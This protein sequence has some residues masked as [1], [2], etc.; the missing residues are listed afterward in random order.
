MN[1]LFPILCGTL[2]GLCCAGIR[3]ARRRTALWMVLSVICGVAATLVS[4]EF[5]LGWEYLFID[6]PLATG[7]ALGVITL[8][9]LVR[10]AS[11][12]RE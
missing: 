5:K 9:R 1:E 7:A 12:A 10:S 6:V 8:R 3:D 11:T 4:G 2:V